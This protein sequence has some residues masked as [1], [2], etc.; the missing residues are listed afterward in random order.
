MQML[1]AS[2]EQMVCRAGHTQRVTHTQLMDHMG[3][4]TRRMH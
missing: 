1:Q 2:T 4:L 3:V